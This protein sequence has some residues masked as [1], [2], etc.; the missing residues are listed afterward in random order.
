MTR[1]AAVES[2][3]GVRQWQEFL[4]GQKLYAGRIDG[5]F[6]PRTQAATVA[7][8]RA[9]ND[10]S[11]L[12]AEA[13]SKTRAATAVSEPAQVTLTP[14]GIVGPLTLAKA[15]DLGYQPPEVGQRLGRSRFDVGPHR[16]DLR[17]CRPYFLVPLLGLAPEE[18]REYARRKIADA[19]LGLAA[20]GKPVTDLYFLSHGWHRN[21]YGAI[22]AYDRLTSRYSALLRRGRLAGGDAGHSPM[23]VTLHWHSDPGDDDFADR[24]GRKG[25]DSYM[26]NV[27]AV[28][29]VDAPRRRAAPCAAANPLNDFEDIFELLSQVSAPGIHALNPLFEE[30]GSELLNALD[31]YELRC[32]RT[33]ASRAEKAAAVWRCY[34]EATPSRVLLDQDAEPERYNTPWQALWVTGKVLVPTVGLSALLLFLFNITRPHLATA[35]S[36]LAQIPLP[37]YVMALAVCLL[38]LAT[39]AAWQQSVH[40]NRRGRTL[41][42]GVALMWV[43]VQ[44]IATVPLL[45]VAL[46][47]FLVG[48]LYARLTG[49]KA[50][51]PLLFDERL[52]RRDDPVSTHAVDRAVYARSALAWLARLPVHLLCAALAPDSAAVGIASALDRQLAFWQMQ[53]KAVEAGRAAARFAADLLAEAEALGG[54]RVHLL[55]HSFGGLVVANAA[56][57]LALDSELRERLGERRLHSICLIEAAL[58]SAWFESEEAL[59]RSV[60]GAIANIYSAYDTANGFYY[61]LGNNGRLAAGSVGMFRVGAEAPER[62]LR[63]ASITS[64]PDLDSPEY[65]PEGVTPRPRGAGPRL[66]NLDASRLIFSGPPAAGGGHSDIYKDDVVHLAAAVTAISAAPPPPGPPS[67]AKPAAADTASPAEPPDASPEGREP[68]GGLPMERVLEEVDTLPPSEAAVRE[69]ERPAVAASRPARRRRAQPPDRRS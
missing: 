17:E 67:A 69:P 52:G 34:H 11:R 47:T 16:D 45:A 31:C 21:F 66:L 51:V 4:A 55:G 40:Q 10:A 18:Q 62:R 7:F 19:A 13:E 20:A 60:D 28:F 15:R 39:A 35:W 25:R 1:K 42:I 23:F 63:F 14:D 30:R 22:E 8:Q 65:L 43:P 6:G 37:V 44:V 33:P 5:Y 29:D 49:C 53:R 61:P 57:H 56:R 12:G 50:P 9:L 36:Y 46:T 48:G 41:P 24:A 27:R 3:E 26:A 64:P 38:V 2:G 54:A 68:G 59:R 58:G 32:A